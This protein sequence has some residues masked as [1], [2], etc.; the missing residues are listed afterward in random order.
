MT[1]RD[2]LLEIIAR[3]KRIEELPENFTLNPE[4]YLIMH[5]L[6]Q[7]R[8]VKVKAS[9]VTSGAAEDIGDP[10]QDYLDRLNFEI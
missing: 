6:Q 1:G 5:S 7:D 3:S 4:D 10:A 9:R 8:P 2:E